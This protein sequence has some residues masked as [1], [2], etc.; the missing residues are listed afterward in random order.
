MFQQLE[1]NDILFIDSSHIIRPQGDV[2]FEYL[3]V[4]PTLKSGVIVHVHDI[5]TP[6]DYLNEWVYNRH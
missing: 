2:L 1:A 5:F 3:E 6:K 4:L